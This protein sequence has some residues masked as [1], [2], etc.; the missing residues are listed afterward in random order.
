MFTNVGGFAP[1]QEIFTTSG[2]AAGNFSNTV[3][4]FYF[5]LTGY[6]NLTGPVEIR[7]VAYEAYNWGHRTALTSF[8]LRVGDTVYPVTVNSA[9]NGT[10]QVDPP[11]TL[12]REGQLIK[13]TASPSVGHHFAGWSG[14]VS[15]LGNPRFVTVDGPKTITANFAPNPPPFMDVGINLDGLADWSTA[16]VF[17]DAFK[18]A[19]IWQTRNA[20]GSGSWGSGYGHLAPVD[21]NG[22]P[23]Q[24]PF[25]PSNGVPPQII[26]TIVN[27]NEAGTYTF[28]Y[29]GSGTLRFRWAGAG[30]TNLPTG[31]ARS[32]TFQ[33]TNSQA[34]A[35]IEIHATTTNDPLRNFR[36]IT[37]G[38]LATY[39]T[40]P[41][42][43]LYLD[44]LQPFSVLRFM[45]WGKINNSTLTSWWQ[46]T[47][48][49]TY[50]QARNEG[51]A[52]E[53]MVALCNTLGKHM[54]LC[55]PAPADDDY[56]RQAARLIRD[57][58]NAGLL[59]F[60]E[61][62][63][64]TWNSLFTQY[65]YV[66]NQGLALGL[67]ANAWNAG[68]KYTAYR[69][70]QIWR[71]FEEE[72]GIGASNRLVKVLAGQAANPAVAQARISAINDPSINPHRVLPD[73]L[74][75]APYFGRTYRP[76]DIPPQAP[77]Y[78]TVDEIVTVVSSQAIASA[79]TYIVNH[80]ALADAQGWALICYEGGQGF[81]GGSGAEND[82]TLTSILISANRDPRMYDRYIEYMDMMKSHGIELFPH[83]SYCGHFRKSGSWGSLEHQDQ[84]LSQAHKYRALVDWIAANIDIQPPT[85]VCPPDLTAN[86]QPGLCSSSVQPGSPLA[87]DNS[88]TVFVTGQRNDG[89]SLTASYP[90][91][92]TL[93]TWTATDPSGNSASCLQTVT[94][95]DA[96]APVISCPANIVTNAPVGQNA[97]SLGIGQASGADNCSSTTIGASRSDGL[98]ITAPFPLGIT[99]VTWTAN[100]PRG[101]LAS[102]LQTITV[103]A[104]PDTT[105]PTAPTNLRSTGQTTSSISLAWNAS[106]DNV[107]VVR[108]RIYRNGNQVGTSTTTT[109]TDS[110]LA[111][112]TQYSY[113]VRA[114]DAAANLSATSNS[115]NVRTKR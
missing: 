2:F 5:P 20:D 15:G 65:S 26:H 29:E 78:P 107:G 79:K 70:A 101:N 48:P 36:I 110:G 14:H 102:C 112:N 77:A 12:F 17:V 40:Q 83:F 114:E 53:Y 71:I 92:T 45:D 90:V 115:I 106:T 95:V 3:F 55:I 31:G 94:I 100:D 37:P 61:Y 7:I 104:T 51:V 109:Y 82:E 87:N 85:I 88:G 66:N 1:G 32:F 80:K 22:W 41:F 64:E 21:E 72:F 89:L 84:P 28:L 73:V 19:R 108:Y 47:R 111:R 68:Q 93:I 113:T 8:E 46:R 34:T 4:S 54:W 62:S 57:S 44:R 96:E 52:L 81:V 91:G 74:A 43:P 13:I 58:L 67:D 56:V 86:N 23:V 9:G 103:N 76:A 49:T 18:E 38:H 50:T 105:P 30:F 98:A 39:Q 6:D 11:G 99:T 10:V 63:N 59:L 35:W 97:V 16:F 33:V 75:I 69:S 42:H 27:L 60:V 25:V 24:V